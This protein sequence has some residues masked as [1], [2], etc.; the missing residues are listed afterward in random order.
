MQKVTNKQ[1]KFQDSLNQDQSEISA[2]D[3]TSSELK[4]FSVYG[5]KIYIGREEITPEKLSILKEEAKYI[6]K[7]ELWEI[8]NAS[9]TNEA[10]TIALI[11]SL[12]FESVKS[13]KMLHHWGH[14]MRNVI[15]ILS[16]ND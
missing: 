9:V 4:V 13:A 5:G 1:E 12:D 3:F 15:H 7:T 10:Y 16:K 11:Q 8:L 2:P 6:E 14:F